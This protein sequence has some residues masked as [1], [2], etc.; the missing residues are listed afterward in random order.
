MPFHAVDQA[1]ELRC[2]AL[3]V[4]VLVLPGPALRRQNPTSVDVLEVPVRESISPFHIFRLL[5]VDPEMPSCVFL[6]SMRF[7][8][9]ILVS[10]GRL[11][12][13]PCVPLVADHTSLPDAALGI[14]ERPPVKVYGHC[15]FP[16]SE[17]L[18][19][20]QPRSGI[21]E[22]HLGAFYCLAVHGQ[23]PPA[24]VHARRADPRRRPCES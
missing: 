19:A 3:D 2:S 14:G 1:V 13:T 15:Y 11:M 17:G 24:I 10:R 16:F 20:I 18:S 6:E 4:E 7:D 22:H 23:S 9:R 5:V 8:E 21:V 12:L